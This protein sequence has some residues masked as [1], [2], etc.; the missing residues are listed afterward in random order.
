M[1]IS[2]A[3]EGEPGEG[4]ISGGVVCSLDLVTHLDEQMLVTAKA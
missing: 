2:I 1:I 4:L 3:L